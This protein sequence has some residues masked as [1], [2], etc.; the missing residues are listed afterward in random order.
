[1]VEI[2]DMAAFVAVVESAGFT[3]AA[4]RLGTTKSVVSRRIGALERELGAPLLDR[5]SRSV[6]STEVGAVYYAKCVRILEAVEAARDFVAGH[7]QLVK[8]RLRIALPADLGAD[9]FL[10]LLDEFAARYPDVLVDAEVEDGRAGPGDGHFDVAIRVGALGD[11]GLV[12]RPLTRC[13]HWLCA[14]P[15]YLRTRGAP[16]APE[17][18]AAHDG[19]M[20]A[21]ADS[22]GFWVLDVDGAPYPCRVRERLRSNSARHLRDAACAGLGLVLAPAP[23]VVD[24][25]AAGRLR[26]LLPQYAPPPQDVSLVYPKN[27]RSSPKVQSLLVFLGERIADPPPWETRIARV[28]QDQD[29]G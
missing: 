25:I 6:R 15:D 20:D 21:K 19:L 17:D 2:A 22:R 27:R 29:R 23:I 1:M 24:A 7:H 14:S 11:S 12:A 3:A 18:L 8:G 16:R 5:S 10:P 9:L 13:R 4:R 26:V 28:L